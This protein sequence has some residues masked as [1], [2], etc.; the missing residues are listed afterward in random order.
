MPHIRDG[1]GS[2]SDPNPTIGERPQTHVLAIGTRSAVSVRR[3]TTSL[4]PNRCAARRGP[5][6]YVE[7]DVP[8][9]G[10]REKGDSP[11]FL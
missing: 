5:F 1:A 6:S 4:P 10:M 9:R 3:H 2:Q 7:V 11:L 8:T